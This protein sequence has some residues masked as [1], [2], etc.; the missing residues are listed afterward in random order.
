MVSPFKACASTARAS[1]LRA[2]NA[3]AGRPWLWLSA[4]A[5]L[6]GAAMAQVAPAEAPPEREV[7]RAASEPEA[8]AATE[9]MEATIEAMGSADPAERENASRALRMTPG[10]TIQ[11]LFEILRR[12]D[13]SPE[14]RARIER[15]GADLFESAPRAAL[16][17]QFQAVDSNRGGVRIEAAVPGFP[18]GDEKLLE[19]GDTLVRAAGLELRSYDDLRAAILAHS[20]GETMRLVV[21]RMSDEAADLPQGPP[22]EPDADGL[23]PGEEELVIDVPLGSFAS[24]NPQRLPQP[25]I[26]L[27]A[28]ETRLRMEGLR[29][30]TLAVPDDAFDDAANW[31][32]G[33]SGAGFGGVAAGGV[34]RS[35]EPYYGRRGMVA[36][37]TRD[38]GIDLGVNVEDLRRQAASLDRQ[39]EMLKL[40]LGRLR[41]MENDEARTAEELARAE[42]RAAQIELEIRQL[43][44]LQ[45]PLQRLIQQQRLEQRAEPQRIERIE[46][47][48]G[49]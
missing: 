42:A 29:G 35:S 8:E 46:R 36:Q 21:R 25:S 9:A 45:Q 41:A 17:V 39:R 14:Q 48:G 23:L 12:E 40:Q 44:L 18:A 30:A 38:L 28:W 26:L 5:G 4:C 33:A 32:G 31:W 27:R 15:V 13:L 16:G 1:D 22:P 7:E 11:S 20:P 19:P 43:D 34:A 10:L 24:L 37:R 2:P 6:A 49:R 3:P 47:P